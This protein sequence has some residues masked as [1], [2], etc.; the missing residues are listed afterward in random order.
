M[1][2]TPKGLSDEKAARMAEVLRGAALHRLALLARF[3]VKFRR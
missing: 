3:A 1:P 2:N